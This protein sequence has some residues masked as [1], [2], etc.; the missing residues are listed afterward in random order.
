MLKLSNAG[1]QSREVQHKLTIDTKA[2]VQGLLCSGASSAGWCW[3]TPQA[4][5]N[6]ADLAFLDGTTGWR[7]GERGEI[8][9]TGDG[10]VTWVAQ[11]SGTLEDLVS[12]AF[13]DSKNGW[14]LGSVDVVLHTRDGGDKWSLS[15]IPAACPRGSA[16]RIKPINAEIAYLSGS[17]VYCATTNGGTS[18]RKLDREPTHVS[19]TGELW[20]FDSAS[21]SI[22]KSA[23]AG[24]T[25]TLVL[26]LGAGNNY[27]SVQILAPKG[28]DVV[29]MGI[30]SKGTRTYR[31]ADGGLRWGDVINTAP[32][33]YDNLFLRSAGSNNNRLVLQT[34]NGTLYYSTDDGKT[35]NTEQGPFKAGLLGNAYNNYRIYLVQGDTFLAEYYAPPD[36]MY[37]RP[38]YFRLSTDVGRTWTAM[39]QPEGWIYFYGPVVAKGPSLLWLKGLNEHR[40]SRDG[41]QTWP[42]LAAKEA[43]RVPRSTSFSDAL[44]GLTVAGR[45]VSETSDGGRTWTVRRDG[46]SASSIVPQVQL[47]DAKLGWLNDATGLF[48]T[49][50]GGRTWTAVKSNPGLSW[51]SARDAQLAV[52]RTAAGIW[53]VTRDGGGSWAE[54]K[55]LNAVTGIKCILFADANR[56]AAIATD[57]RHLFSRDAGASWST[58]TVGTTT[59]TAVAGLA[60]LWAP[61]ARG[62]VM[63]SLNGGEQWA[64]VAIGNADARV[65]A[66]KFFDARIGWLVGEA[67]LLMATTD[68]GQTWRVQ[69]SLVQEDLRAIDVVDAKTAW[70]SGSGGA[71]LSTASGGN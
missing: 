7:V 41:G 5:A 64:T 66:V 45:T 48:K 21:N 12:V 25:W 22:L 61:G 54:L 19:D 23:D 70:I 16:G 42:V 32:G 59:G 71:L 46:S 37:A 28:Q 53:Q 31:S 1:G 58:A 50:D 67:G 56:W 52:G 13:S 43:F 34:D 4:S 30:W 49:A 57:G 10:G 60:P 2:N 40:L 38:R 63:Q 29:V 27:L 17:E 18:W 26:A 44:H 62:M 8:A 15:R 55:G 24:L 47:I 51:L 35:W 20:Y 36:G 69:A 65:L 68:G 33:S 6:L 11:R 9:K 39:T 14:A 3:Q